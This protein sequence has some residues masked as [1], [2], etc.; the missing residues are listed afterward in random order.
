M[1]EDREI[2][3]DGLREGPR[4]ADGEAR[5]SA[6]KRG[7]GNGNKAAGLPASP[8]APFPPEGEKLKPSAALVLRQLLLS[9]IAAA[10]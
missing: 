8:T 3:L 9:V 10:A 4:A 7:I 1:A 6:R 5:R 2:G